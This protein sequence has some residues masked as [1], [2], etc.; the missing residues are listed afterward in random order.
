MSIQFKDID[1]LP[2]WNN[3]KLR[4][5]L[6]LFVLAANAFTEHTFHRSLIVTSVFR[7]YEKDKA[8][9]RSG[10]HGLWRAVDVS[11]RGWSAPEIAKICDF[12]N[13]T[14]TY[15]QGKQIC[16]AHDAGS[17]MHW[18]FQVPAGAPTIRYA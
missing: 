13:E 18:H 12:V 8:L 6:K 10:M 1:L 5:D 3:K 7:D 9:G 4:R 15:G 16:F 11:A 2:E 17:G 14:V